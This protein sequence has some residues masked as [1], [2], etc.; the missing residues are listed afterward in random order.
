MKKSEFI[1]K[2]TNA[3]PYYKISMSISLDL[4]YERLKQIN[5]LKDKLEEVKE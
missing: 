2:Y 1:E 4:L 5:C 3:F